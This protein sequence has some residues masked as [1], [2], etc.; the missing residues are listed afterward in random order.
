MKHRRIR[1][2]GP[3]QAAKKN[4]SLDASVQILSLSLDGRGVARPSGKALFVRDALPGEEVEVAIEKS[5]KRFDEGVV[6]A[7]TIASEHRVEPACKFYG[8]CGGCD[9]QHLNPETAVE[10]KQQE[11]LKQLETRAKIEPET[12][13]SPLIGTQ[14]LGYRRAARVGINQ[15][16]SGDLLIGFR[17][18]SSA[19]LVDIDHCPVLTDRINQFLVELRATLAPFERV[20]HLTQI[21]LI[22][23]Q[24]GVMAELRSTKNISDELRA[25]LIQLAQSLQVQ[26]SLSVKDGAHKTLWENRA[27]SE[28]QICKDLSLE[29]EARDFVQVNRDINEQMIGRVLEWLAPQTTDRALDLFS[30]LGNFSLP[31][32]QQIETL[33]AVEGSANMVE[34]CL[35]NA[36]RNGISNIKSYSADLSQPDTTCTWLQQAY[37]LIILDPPRQGAAEILAAMEGQKPRALVYI[38][39]DPASLVRDAMTLTNQGYR[40]SRLCV[41][42][43]FPQTHH[44]ESLALFERG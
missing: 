39:C 7:V 23:G 20:K 18:R 27:A 25:S 44:I 34:R 14:K 11:L 16:E 38:A 36:K 28:L 32:A 24:S 42:D 13:D 26:L 33:T 29:F 12:I 1:Y 5:G 40:M 4:Q 35:S 31:L 8:Q 22:E 43:M 10:L 30:G 15:R 9:L 6:S 17:R 2:G 19:K 3:R 37:D 21:E 41:A